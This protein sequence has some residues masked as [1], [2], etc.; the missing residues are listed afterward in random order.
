LP[1]LPQNWG[2]YHYLASKER[3]GEAAQ[4]KMVAERKIREKEEKKEI[5]I[6]SRIIKSRR[7]VPTTKHLKKEVIKFIT[8]PRLDVNKLTYLW[9]AKKVYSILEKKFK[10]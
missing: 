6:H 7:Y 4:Q 3:F 1:T 2:E 5:N 8:K 10:K 9:L